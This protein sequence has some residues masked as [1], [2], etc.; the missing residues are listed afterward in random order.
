[1]HVNIHENDLQNDLQNDLIFEMN[2]GQMGLAFFYI[3]ATNQIAGF[4]KLVYL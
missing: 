3:V 2:F 4:M 1:M